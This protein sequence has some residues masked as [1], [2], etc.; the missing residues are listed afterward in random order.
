LLFDWELFKET[1]PSKDCVI[2]GWKL[3]LNP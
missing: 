3:K 2:A 1:E